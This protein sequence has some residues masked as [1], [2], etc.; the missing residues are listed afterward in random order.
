MEVNLV[1]IDPTPDS[2]TRRNFLL[3]ITEIIDGILVAPRLDETE[4][5]E[6]LLVVLDCNLVR[7]VHL[8][9]ILAIIPRYL[10]RDPFKLALGTNSVKWSEARSV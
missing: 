8:E 7:K 3:L 1:R 5:R 6:C 2:L 4:V 9:S 10:A